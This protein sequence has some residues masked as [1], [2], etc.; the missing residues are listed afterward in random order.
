MNFGLRNALAI[1]SMLICL[2][3]SIY[4]SPQRPYW[5]SR[6]LGIGINYPKIEKNSPLQ[7]Y[8]KDKYQG[9]SD[10]SYESID[11]F[12]IEQQQQ[13][14]HWQLQNEPIRSQQ[15]HNAEY[16]DRFHKNQESYYQTLLR[17]TESPLKEVNNQPSYVTAQERQIYYQDYLP[18]DDDDDKDSESLEIEDSYIKK[19][20][21]VSNPSDKT[22][23]KKGNGINS[24][25]EKFAEL[26]TELLMKDPTRVPS[27]NQVNALNSL[28]DEMIA[29]A[30]VP[31][32]IKRRVRQVRGQQPE[33][34]WTLA[35][36]AFEVRVHISFLLFNQSRLFLFLSFIFL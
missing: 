11:K 3:D 28:D 5:A 20:S 9:S 6:E 29:E 13:Q 33:L 25:E 10:S 24:V 35:R 7:F 15:N 22:D 26:V 32:E 31:E 23:P 2:V 17:V 36:L 16:L 19:S 4:C 27:L 8:H 14:H 34:I 1:Y 18:L 12:Q 30:S 21:A